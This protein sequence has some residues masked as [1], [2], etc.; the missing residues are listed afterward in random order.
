MFEY[1][2]NVNNGKNILGLGEEIKRVS[3]KSEN[4]TNIIPGKY[5]GKETSSIVSA[6]SNIEKELN[7][8]GSELERLGENIIT[9]AK[10]IKNIEDQKNNS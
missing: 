8:I 10:E 4:I 9:V 5:R 7:S 3:R 6:M 1:I 2:R